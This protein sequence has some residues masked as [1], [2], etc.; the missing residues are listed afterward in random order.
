MEV[1][2]GRLGGGTWRWRYMEVEV[3]GGGGTWR[4]V[5]GGA[6]REVRWRCVEGG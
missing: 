3:H 5:G 1:H 2:G 4:E 6:W